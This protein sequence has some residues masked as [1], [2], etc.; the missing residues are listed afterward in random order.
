MDQKNDAPLE[1]SGSGPDAAAVTK[2]SL[3]QSV[4]NAVRDP[5]W[6]SAASGCGILALAIYLAFFSDF[7][8]AMEA[9]IRAE[10]ASLIQERTDL[11]R[12]I[13]NLRE[14][15]RDLLL[16]TQ[17]LSARET[18]IQAELASAYV[19]LETLREERSL[20]EAQMSR[21][22]DERHAQLAELGVLQDEAATLR[23]TLREETAAYVRTQ[24]LGQG[25][26]PPQFRVTMQAIDL[27]D[28]DPERTAGAFYDAAY[29][30]LSDGWLANET[31]YSATA[32]AELRRLFDQRCA[33]RSEF[34]SEAVAVLPAVPPEVIA[35]REPL[36]QLQGTSGDPVIDHEL[37]NERRGQEFDRQFIIRDFL[38]S[39]RLALSNT[40]AGMLEA[41]VAP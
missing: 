36:P 2:L 13:G 17:Q 19:E 38:S 39:Q 21:L 20:I 18:S 34:V 22:T 7:S 5:G 10:N 3:G 8:D 40:L 1:P 16:E 28:F 15:Q 9:Y 4:A 29:L 24:L 32:R 6:W 12:D 26:V 31:S 25:A 35:A 30:A 37:R 41:C 27:V 33:E 11:R 23:A 14:E